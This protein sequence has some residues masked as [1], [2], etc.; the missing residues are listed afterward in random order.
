MFTINFSALKVT[1]T[2]TEINVDIR[3]R[4]GSVFISASLDS[5]HSVGLGFW[6][7]QCS[8]WINRPRLFPPQEIIQRIVNNGCQLVPRSSP[9]GDADAEWRFSFSGP[10]AVL[11]QL[12]SKEQKCSYY[13]FKVLFY[14]Y[15]KCVESTEPEA[16]SLCS[17]MVKTTM[18]WACEELPPENPIWTR[19]E[20][21]VQMLLVKLSSS[22]EAGFLPHYFI[23]EINLLERVG[24]DVKR[25]CSA[26]IGQ[27]QNNNLMAAPFDMPEKREFMSTLHAFAYICT[28]TPLL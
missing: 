27:L 5:V 10:E 8:S 20:K 15:L 26:I 6:P 3:S 19:L 25:K 28:S 16:K 7:H 22:L 1:E 18:L 11:A 4:D 21:S 13:F 14:R 24:E 12:R 2:T 17:Y 9:G 23:P